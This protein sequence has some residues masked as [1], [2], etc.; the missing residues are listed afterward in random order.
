MKLHINAGSPPYVANV[1]AKDGYWIGGTA[2]PV[3]ESEAFDFDRDH[4]PST[5]LSNDRIFCDL[6]LT[7][8]GT[9]KLVSGPPKQAGEYRQPERE[10][11]QQRISDLKPVAKERRPEFGS[12]LFA[13]LAM[14]GSI[15]LIRFGG[16]W[17][18]VAGVL[19]ALDGTFGVL[20]GLDLWSLLKISM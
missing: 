6:S 1:D 11:Y 14:A 3:K 8:T 2:S 15:A 7:L 5:L 12:L 13:L 20:L 9:P 16:R 10:G 17:G 4:D 19:L 18:F